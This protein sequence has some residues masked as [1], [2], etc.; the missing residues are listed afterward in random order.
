M[1]AP[2]PAFPFQHRHCLD[3]LQFSR[4]D[5]DFL[6]DLGA[7]YLGTDRPR[8]VLK[9]ATVVNLF[10]ENSTRTEKSF[11]IAAK[12]LGA[13]VVNMNVATSSVAKGETRAPG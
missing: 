6:L 13:D 5:I 3:I 8:R 7:Y 2:E 1:S 11:E 12:R 10:F 9:R 4:P